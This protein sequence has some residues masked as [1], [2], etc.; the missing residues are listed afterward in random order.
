MMACHSVWP[1]ILVFLD[2]GCVFEYDKIIGEGFVWTTV[3]VCCTIHMRNGKVLFEPCMLLPQYILDNEPVNL[4]R[5]L[6]TS[7][8][9]AAVQKILYP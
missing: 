3:P 9:F 2:E 1:I 6:A 5:C 8:I 4:E 7:I